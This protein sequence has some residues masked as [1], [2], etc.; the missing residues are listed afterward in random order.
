MYFEFV[1][2]I[3]HYIDELH[4]CSFFFT[5][6]KVFTVWLYYHLCIRAAIGKHVD[7]FQFGV[8]IAFWGFSNK[9]PQKIEMLS[10]T[11]LANVWNQAIWR[12]CSQ[13][14]ALGE[15]LCL[16]CL[17]TVPGASWLV[18][19]FSNLSLSLSSHGFLSLFSLF[20]SVS[21]EDACHWI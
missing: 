6:Y 14:K 11:F 15:N 9:L 1:S 12:L 4:L 10:L 20:S 3:S 7:N 18:A 5:C 16:S 17:L 21:Y 19:H 13:L 2:L 8:C